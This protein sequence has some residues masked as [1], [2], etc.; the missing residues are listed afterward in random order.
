MNIFKLFLCLF[1]ININFSFNGEID[2]IDY[3][4]LATKA[5][6]RHSDSIIGVQGKTDKTKCYAT[7]DIKANET[8]F[9]YDKKNILSSETCF[10]PR[11]EE[12]LKN[13]SFYTNDTYQQKAALL[14][15]CVYFA[16]KDPNN[17]SIPK[18]Q[19]F[20]LMTL[21]LNDSKYSEMQFNFPDLNE[22]LLTGTNFTIFESD[23]IERIIKRN[24]QI[25]DKREKD[26]KFFAKIYYY[27]RYH[28]F[29]VSNQVVILPFIEICNIAPNYLTKPDTNI[30][31]SSIVVETDGAIIVKATKDLKQTDQFALAFGERLD[32]DYLMLKQGVFAHDNIH[33]NYIINKRF[34]FEHT[35][36]TDELAHNL[37]KHNLHPSLLDYRRENMGHDAWFKLVL[38]ANK[39]SDVLYRFGIIYF[40]WHNFHST[41][42]N[43]EYRHNAKQAM[44]LILRMCYDEMEEI[45]S[46]MKV[47]L[48]EYLLKTQTDNN[49]T[50][51]NK[52]LRE[53]SSEKIHL[54]QKNIKY[55][56]QELA[57]LNY[58]EIK[59]KK[60]AYT[61]FENSNKS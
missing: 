20:Y 33:D 53:F 31:N 47:G 2:E 12:A 28:S 21:P 52:K 15:F 7:K 45:K 43:K 18:D 54:I 16:L 48:D 49:I 3:L 38:E 11:K 29:F 17:T 6:G 35:Y 10:Y 41:D 56:Y 55:L 61:N 19:K 58:N 23:N 32:N 24:L 51:L 59:N 34:S 30:Y 8:L 37:K 13:I 42:A 44:T 39:I 57:F 40:F 27:V 26:F 50:E 22:F 36:E 25:Y 1:L 60:D 4:Y 5:L 46:R 14:A 9:T